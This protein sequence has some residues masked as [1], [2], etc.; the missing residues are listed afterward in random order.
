MINPNRLDGSFP[1]EAYQLP[2]TSAANPQAESVDAYCEI[3]DEPVQF[4]GEAGQI[5]N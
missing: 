5:S 2:K 4:V 3:L 1:D